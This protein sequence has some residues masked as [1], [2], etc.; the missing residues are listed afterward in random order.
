MPTADFAV[1]ASAATA[2]FRDWSAVVCV[3]S[4]VSCVFNAVCGADSTAISLV[5]MPAGVEAAGQAG[6]AEPGERGGAAGSSMLL[7]VTV[8]SF[9]GYWR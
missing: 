3:C 9:P 7:V 2:A 4:V 5:M 6:E 1:V 8:Q